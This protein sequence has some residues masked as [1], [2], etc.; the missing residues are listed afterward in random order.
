ME[1]APVIVFN[2]N[3]PDHSQQVWDALSKNELAKETELYLYCDGPK[4]LRSEGVNELTNERIKESNAR[5]EWTQALAK[6]YAIEAQKAGKFKAV[7]V[8]CSEKNKGLRTSI[9]SGATEVINKHGRVIVLEDDLVT[10]PYFLNY[11]N[12]AL[13]KYESY[14]GV[15]SI[16]SQSYVNPK[17]FPQDYPYDVYAYPTHMPT[18]W[19]TWVDRWKLVEWDID[20]QLAPVLA[21]EPYMRNAFMRGGEDLYYRSLIERL[22]GLDVWSICFSLAHFKHHAVSITPIVSYIHN[23]GFDGSGVN[24]GVK[25]D[26]FLNHNYYVDA[27][28]DPR[29]L[30]VVYEDSRIVNIVYSSSVLHRRPFFKR[31]VNRIM[32]ML[33][34]RTNYILKGEVYKV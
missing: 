10:S 21:N 17:E 11:M 24:S 14:R 22:K 30:D 29:L 18:G 9:I 6:E 4:E 2:Y 8:V 34:G 16:G 7:H 19:A 12:K 1:L 26:P 31:I 33:T 15:F 25:D 28:K 32:C 27:V 13:D 23:I 20:K 5:V 3:R